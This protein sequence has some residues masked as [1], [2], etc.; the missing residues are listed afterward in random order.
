MTKQA[1]K[2][3]IFNMVNEKFYNIPKPI[4]YNTYCC[5]GAGQYVMDT[6]KDHHGEEPD[7]EQMKEYFRNNFLPEITDIGKIQML[8]STIEYLMTECEKV[9]EENLE[10]KKQFRNLQKLIKGCDTIEKFN[11]LKELPFM[12]VEDECACEE[13]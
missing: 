12:K 5:C 1:T 2:Q 6:H 7:I 11:M 10:H 4:L 8:G 3:E 13:K 9:E